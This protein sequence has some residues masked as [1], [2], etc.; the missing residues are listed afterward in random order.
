MNDTATARFGLAAGRA[1]RPRPP[2]PPRLILKVRGDLTFLHLQ[3][4]DWI[5]ADGNYV[6]VHAGAEIFVA[7][8]TVKNIMQ[9]LDGRFLRVHRSAIVNTDQIRQ[10]LSEPSGQVSIVLRNGTRILAGRYIEDPLREWM[11]GAC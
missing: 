9:R 1:I 5:E 6:R 2:A 8:E 7:R 11:N 3:E 10:I 4:I